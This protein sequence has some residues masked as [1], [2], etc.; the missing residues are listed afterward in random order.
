MPQKNSV[1]DVSFEN[2][3]QIS[4][5]LLAHKY[6]F[7][8]GETNT[9]YQYG[10]NFSGFVCP[11]SGM[12]VYKPYE[13]EAFCAQ[14]GT[15]I[16]LPQMSKYIVECHEKDFTHYTVNFLINSAETDQKSKL[17][18]LFGNVPLKTST[19]NFDEF[20]NIFCKTV[21]SFGSNMFGATLLV[22]AQIME[23]IQMFFSEAAK[24]QAVKG[25]YEALSIAK[26]YME[27]YFCEC[28]R[29]AELASLCSMSETNFRRKFKEYFG[30]PP[31][32]Y[33]IGLKIRRAKELLLERKYMV[34]QVARL[35]GF[36]DVNYFS[37]LF[38]KRIGVSPQVFEKMY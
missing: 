26:E 6:T 31:H 13:S 29:A 23:L 4:E 37:R 10:R 28:L 21:S 22:K 18:E 17:W 1:T 12:A 5:V 14:P 34:G 36:D 9:I 38:K 3:I 27:N 25:E 30:Q 19:E 35:V 16:Y 8:R 7:Y 32:D 20:R 11:L 24:T 15:V 2:S 33:Q